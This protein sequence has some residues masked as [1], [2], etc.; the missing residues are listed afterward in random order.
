MTDATTAFFTAL[1]RRGTELTLRGV[2]ATVRFDVTGGNVVQHWL[3]AISDGEVG[4]SPGESEADCAIGVDERVLDAIVTGRI[5]PMAALLRGQLDVTG[6]A[7]LLVLVKRLFPIDSP[8]P[9]WRQPATTG[10]WRH[11]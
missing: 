3:V 8:P 5:N 1:N 6:N 11:A 9:G 4:V 7:D 2:D 10:G